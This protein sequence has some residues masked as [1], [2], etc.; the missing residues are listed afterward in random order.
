MAQIFTQEMSQWTPEVRGFHWR[1]SQDKT[2]GV[3]TE[4]GVAYLGQQ[5]YTKISK[6]SFDCQIY[7]YI[8]I[9]GCF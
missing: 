6:V 8:K 9:S 2:K 7:F 1:I 5:N 3:K 4:G